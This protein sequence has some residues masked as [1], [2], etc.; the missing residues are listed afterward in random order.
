MRA[1]VK[2]NPVLAAALRYSDHG[3]PVPPCRPR[4]KVPCTLHRLNDATRVHGLTW[5]KSLG[6]RWEASS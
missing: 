2:T 5:W 3:L 6:P 1:R 4:S